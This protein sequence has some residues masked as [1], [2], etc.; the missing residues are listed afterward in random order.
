MSARLEEKL[1][2]FIRQSLSKADIHTQIHLN[3]C[4]IKMVKYATKCVRNHLLILYIYHEPDLGSFLIL[5][6]FKPSTK[7]VGN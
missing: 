7:D 1:M 2:W 6:K 4:S 5:I 3:L